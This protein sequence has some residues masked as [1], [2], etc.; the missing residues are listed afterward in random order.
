MLSGE[1]RTV[2]ELGLQENI[3]APSYVAKV[4][5]LRLLAPDIIESILDG[6]HPA[7]WT[8]EKLFTVKSTKWQEQ[9]K[10]LGLI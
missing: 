1:K 3:K 10:A 5:Y 8:V 2:K 6:T 4:M 7:D 9:R